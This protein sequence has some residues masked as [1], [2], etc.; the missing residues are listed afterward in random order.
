MWGILLMTA[1]FVAI[2]LGGLAIYRWH[3]R[4]GH[5]RARAMTVFAAFAVT[6]SL[7]FF[8]VSSMLDG[9]GWREAILSNVKFMLG[10]AIA[11]PAATA[12]WYLVGTSW[13]QRK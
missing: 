5:T 3:E 4:R 11:G 13:G 6:V 8:P 9:V 7:V 1:Y 10:V 2:P 12:A